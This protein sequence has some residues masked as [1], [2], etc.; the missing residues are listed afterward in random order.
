MNE[1][2][3]ALPCPPSMSLGDIS[4]VRPV[5]LK[6]P[7]VVNDEDAVRKAQPVGVPLII[8]LELGL[9]IALVV[10]SFTNKPIFN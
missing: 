8:D 4:S 7:L 9:A 5:F 1:T 2:S 10:A 6:R 3:K